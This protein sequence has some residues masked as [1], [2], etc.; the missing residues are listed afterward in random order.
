VVLVNAVILYSTSFAPS[1]ISAPYKSKSQNVTP[2]TAGST[3]IVP[4]P[5]TPVPF[6]IKNPLALAV[7]AANVLMIGIM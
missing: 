6:K 5:D 7:A 2:F 3:L 4:V 1:R